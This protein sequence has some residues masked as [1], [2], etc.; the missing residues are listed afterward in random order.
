MRVRLFSLSR[1]PDDEA[2]EVRQLLS[3]NGIDFYETHAGGWGISTPAIWLYDDAEQD[4][5][6]ALLDAYQQQR[7][8]SAQAE[9]K[10]RR[11]S[12]QHQTVLHR[13][14]EHPLQVLLLSMLIMFILYV[15]LSPFLN[16]LDQLSALLF[17]L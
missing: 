8:A 1:V 17:P 3:D 11:D 9:Y 4:R 6:Q 13:I 14:L 15:S 16:F 12:G 7:Q 2:A 5:A 10:A